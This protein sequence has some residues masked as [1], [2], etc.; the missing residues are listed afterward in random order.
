[1]PP[2]DTK[3]GPVAPSPRVRSR[4]RRVR[5][6]VRV[7]LV[8]CVVTAPA[9]IA[10]ADEIRWQRL[11]RDAVGS[12]HRALPPSQ[13]DREDALLALYLA[14]RSPNLD[15]FLPAGGGGTVFVPSLDDVRGL[16][17]SRS[18]SILVSLQDGTGPR[19]Q[20]IEIHERAHLAHA[21]LSALVQDILASLPPP[22]PSAYAAKNNKEHFAEMASE[23]WELLQ[24]AGN[25]CSAETPQE[26]LD[27]AESEVPG[28]SGFVIYFLQQP[29][30]AALPY[31]PLLRDAASRHM[32]PARESWER[33]Y[34]A[35]DARRQSDGTLK[36]WPVPTMREW[37]A[38]HRAELRAEGGV[39]G[40]VHA[41]AFFP[42][43][44]LLRLMGA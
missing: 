35:L 16:A 38:L 4:L 27:R 34:A 22:D 37:V 29:A 17:F 39:L 11:T 19:L 13:A 33:L 40:H 10:R 7:F 28:T 18:S 15:A 14:R 23:A 30:F 44:V 32:Q 31:A 3:A 25:V 42:S 43:A 41:M 36:A 1:M 9:F 12:T 24:P 26:Q 8:M 2:E 5:L 6:Y 20:A 21:Q